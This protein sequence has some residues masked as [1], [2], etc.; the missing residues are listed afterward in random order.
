MSRFLESLA[1]GAL[2]QGVVLR[3]RARSLYE[4]GGIVEETVEHEVIPVAPPS[5]VR[6]TAPSTPVWTSG[7]RTEPAAA[8]PVPPAE[9]PRPTDAAPIEEHAPRAAH[10][11]VT[12]TVTVHRLDTDTLAPPATPMV[13]TA[14]PRPFTPDPSPE[15][16]KVPREHVVE[17]VTELAA[18]AQPPT[19]VIDRY[20]AGR[21][22]ERNERT[23]PTAS[24][25]HEPAPAH[26]AAPSAPAPAVPVRS[27]LAEAAP[28]ARV[29]GEPE[30]QPDPVIQVSIG[31]IEV[32]ATGTQPRPVTPMPPRERETAPPAADGAPSLERYLSRL[33]RR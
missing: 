17:V 26:P 15:P 14:D 31:H 23:E 25:V 2:G 30:P 27:R 21:V 9:V 5:S 7:A 32:R 20:L 29:A 22:V 16:P 28:T 3:P 33:E 13:L 10:D 6:T 4:S 12:R 8:G 1:L 18:P 11:E 24:T 19:E